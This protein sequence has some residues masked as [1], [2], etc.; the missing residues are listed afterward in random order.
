MF[1]RDLRIGDIFTTGKNGDPIHVQTLNELCV[2]R[3]TPHVHVVTSVGVSCHGFSAVI[4]GG[5]K[6][7][8]P[9]K[10]KSPVDQIN[11]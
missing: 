11:Q 9:A 10:G 1:A 8:K 6:A 4:G 7:G 5:R 3:P 2:E